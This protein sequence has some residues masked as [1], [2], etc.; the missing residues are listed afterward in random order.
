[1]YSQDDYCGR[2]NLLTPTRVK[3]AAA[4]IRTG[5]T[6]PLDLPSNVPAVPGFGRQ[7]FKHKIQPLTPGKSYDDLY[8]M[9]TQ[10]GTQWDGFRHVAHQATEIFYNNTS[11]ADFTNGNEQNNQCSIHHWRDNGFSGRGVLLDYKAYAEHTGIKHNTATSHEITYDAL[12]EVGKHQGLDIRPT[13]QGGDIQPGDILLIRT[14]WTSD[15]YSRTAEESK[16]IAQR[17]EQNWVGVKP[18]IE[19][20]DWLHDCYF[21]AVGGDQP[22]FERWPPT[23]TSLIPPGVPCLHEYLLSFWG[24][25]IGEMLDLEK[26][27]ELAKKNN[28]WT[29]FVSSAPF[30]TVGGVASWVNGTAIF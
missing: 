1:M 3:A 2:L 10:S 19:M 12:V 11:P 18:T 23:Q 16:V 15:Y 13:S 20:I 17:S 30:R 24:V 8:D 29:F 14:G 22:A 21:S 6:A 25:P 28:R 7:E 26:V 4:E 27:S 9:N 5:E